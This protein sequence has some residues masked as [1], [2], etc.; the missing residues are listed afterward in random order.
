[1]N[2]KISDTVCVEIDDEDFEKVWGYSWSVSKNRVFRLIPRRRRTISMASH[3][4][5]TGQLY[6]YDHIDRN[7]LN[8]RKENLRI[9]SHSQNGINRAKQSGKSSIYKG[10]SK[11]TKTGKFVAQ[12]KKDGIN[13]HVGCFEFEKDAAVAYNKKAVELFGEFAVLNNLSPM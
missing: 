7:P 3:I 13:H 2:F 11:I 10:V 1:V 4:M 8:N 6:M 12:I 9:A 5:G